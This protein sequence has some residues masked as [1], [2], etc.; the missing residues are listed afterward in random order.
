MYKWSFTNSFEETNKLS[1]FTKKESVY[2]DSDRFNNA[3][4]AI[5]L[6]KGFLEV[7]PGIF[8]YY[9]QKFSLCIISEIV[10]KF[11]KRCLLFR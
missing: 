6:N 10:S 9:L 3:N 4:S 5:N 7:S 8:I 11:K 2:L 1:V